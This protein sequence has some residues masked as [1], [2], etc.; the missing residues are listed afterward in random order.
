[1]RLSFDVLE[2]RYTPE[3]HGT[4]SEIKM[5]LEQINDIEDL[6]LEGETGILTLLT[7]ACIDPFASTIDSNFICDCDGENELCEGVYDDACDEN[8]NGILESS[9]IFNDGCSLPAPDF[10][11]ILSDRIGDEELVVEFNSYTLTIPEGTV[12]TFP[13]SETSLDIISSASVNINFLPDVAP[14]AQLAGSLVGIYPFG[15]TF[16]PPIEFLFTFEDLSRGTSEYKILYMD[17]IQMGDWDEIG[18]CVTGE[19]NFRFC[20]IE[21]LSSSG[22]FIVMYGENL[23]IDESIIPSV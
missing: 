21:E 14:G 11:D 4:T 17:D 1:M 5:A 20:N 12:I 15:T 19:N 18:T 10:P 22:L 7:Q 13:D 8:G 16:D 9:H 23:S 2:S 6:N 3:L